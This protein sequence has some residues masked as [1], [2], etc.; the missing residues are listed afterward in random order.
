MA[1]KAAPTD[2]DFVELIK[3]YC[4]KIGENLNKAVIALMDVVTFKKCI[5]YNIRDSAFK[6]FSIQQTTHSKVRH[7]QYNKF[8]T[9]P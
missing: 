9:Q 2:G 1:Q 8:A 7:I 4:I 3:N 5:K 6:S